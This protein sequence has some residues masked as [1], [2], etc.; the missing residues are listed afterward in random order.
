MGALGLAAS[1]EVPARVVRYPWDLV[2]L[3]ADEIAADAAAIGRVGEIR[4]SVHPGAHLVEPGR[5]AIGEGSTVAPGAVIDATAGP[6]LIGSRAAVM[7]NAV[8]LG[9]AAV[10]DGSSVKVGAKIYGGTSIGPACKVGG[11]VEGSVFQSHTNKQHD[12]FLGHSYLASWVNIGAATDNSDLKNNYGSVRVEIGGEVVDTGLTFVGATIGDHTKTAIGTKLNTGTVIGVFCNVLAT[13]F[14]PK[15]IPAFSWG[16]PD[17]FVPYDVEKAL[18]TAR[19]VMAR[20][21]E[22]LTAAE[23]ALIRSVHRGGAPG[24]GLPVTKA[25][26]PRPAGRGALFIR[27]AVSGDQSVLGFLLELPDLLLQFLDLG[28]E[29]FDGLLELGCLLGV[30]DADHADSHRRRPLA[31]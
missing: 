22:K 12:G 15:N 27:G 23:E 1:A 26:A 30:P 10:G 4:G 9:P 20:R 21:G 28:L 17:G 19:R 8:V 18:D 24:V 25:G 5:I 16:G 11:E 31:P 3:T 14:P 7:A 2:R 29:L 13:G 6:V